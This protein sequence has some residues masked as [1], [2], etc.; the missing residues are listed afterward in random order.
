MPLAERCRNLREWLLAGD[1]EQG[2]AALDVCAEPSPAPNAGLPRW[3]GGIRA[4]TTLLLQAGKDWG[5][6]IQM[7][8]YARYIAERGMRVV[9]Q[10]PREIEGVLQTHDGVALTYDDREAVQSGD[11]VLPMSSLP[12]PRRQHSAEYPLSVFAF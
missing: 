2:L 8:R 6:A 10:C 4:N 12:H 9:V 11:Y 3:D 5:E 7:V 1:Y